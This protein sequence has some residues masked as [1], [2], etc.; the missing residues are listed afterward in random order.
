M[1]IDK[2]CDVVFG[3]VVSK[4]GEIFLLKCTKLPF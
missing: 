1:T 4:M 3:N 2:C